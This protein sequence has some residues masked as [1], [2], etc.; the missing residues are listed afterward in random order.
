MDFAAF[1]HYVHQRQGLDLR[2]AQSYASNMR[3]VQRVAGVVGA[4]DRIEPRFRQRAREAGMSTRSVNSC[5]PAIRAFVAYCYAE[6]LR[7]V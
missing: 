6:P 2:S 5:L 1:E 3:R 7:R 4:P